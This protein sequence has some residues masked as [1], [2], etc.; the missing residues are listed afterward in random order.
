M[1]ERVGG[2]KMAEKRRTSFMDD[3]QYLEWCITYL[4][5]EPLI[6][7]ARPNVVGGFRA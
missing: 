3:P 6:I 7:G 5:A 2:S 4:G 1:L